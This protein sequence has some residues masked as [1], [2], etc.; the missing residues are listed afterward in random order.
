[1][2]I[3]TICSI[4]AVSAQEDQ[5]TIDIHELKEHRV[6]IEERDYNERPFV[7]VEQIPQFKGG[8]NALR[9]FIDNNLKYPELSEENGI[10]GRV[11]L[12]FVVKKD[13][14]IS[15]I[16]ILRGLDSLCDAEAIRVIQLMP[17]WIPGKQNGQTVPVYYT[18]P[19]SFRFNTDEA[20]DPV[21]RNENVNKKAIFDGNLDAYFKAHYIEPNLPTKGG[22]INI[23]F[24]IEKDG[25]ISNVKTIH[26]LNPQYDNAAV[27]F[28]KSM[29]KW[30]PAEKDGIVVRNI[31][32]LN[33]NVT[34]KSSNKSQ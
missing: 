11:I 32:H 17:D 16:Q 7:S 26:S 25:T 29:P 2:S 13:G 1:M 4:F 14:S 34:Y 8:E 30:V 28:I 19:I 23:S 3:N 18:L 20:S 6:I 31:Q 21:Y 12:R 22:R 27:K 5:N 24:I 10:E 33:F 15:D 9:E